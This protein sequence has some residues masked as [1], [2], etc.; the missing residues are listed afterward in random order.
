MFGEGQN[1]T[2]L[3]T[4]TIDLRVLSLDGEMQSRLQ[5]DI[6]QIQVGF[7]RTCQLFGDFDVIVEGGQMKGRVT[8]VL[9]L[10]N[11]PRPRK[12]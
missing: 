12:F 2:L 8:V 7:S 10:V 11:Y 4:R 9:F 3:R 6:L 5:I 1:W